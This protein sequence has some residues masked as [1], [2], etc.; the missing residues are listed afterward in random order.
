[1]SVPG[2]PNLVHS[3]H[4]AFALIPERLMDYGLSG[5]ATKVYIGLA[6]Y[7]DRKGQAFPSL[8]ALGLRTHQSVSSVQRGLAELKRAGLVRV[9]YR[10][11]PRGGQR[12][13]L[14]QLMRP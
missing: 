13:N 12:S 1:M 7:A 10:I 6:L 11:R 8:S 9:V 14:Y 5:R 2:D 3:W 4:G